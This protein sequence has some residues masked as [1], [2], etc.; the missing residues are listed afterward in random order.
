LA[1]K[2]GFQ[3]DLAE[4][5]QHLKH[6]KSVHKAVRNRLTNE[7]KKQIAEEQKK[8]LKINKTKARRYLP[9]KGF[10]PQGL[11]KGADKHALDQI[12]QAATASLDIEQ[13]EP[14]EG[15]EEDAPL[16]LDALDMHQERFDARGEPS[17]WHGLDEDV[18]VRVDRDDDEEA[19]ENH[20]AKVNT[21]ERNK[22]LLA[23]ANKADSIVPNANLRCDLCLSD[24]TQTETAKNRKY[25]LAKLNIHLGSA[26]HSRRSQI[27]RAFNLDAET[28]KASTI[29]C[30]IC[31]LG[32]TGRGSASSKFIA[33]IEEHHPEELWETDTEPDSMEVEE[34]DAEEEYVIAANE[35]EDASTG[36]GSEEQPVES[37]T[38]KGKGRAAV[39]G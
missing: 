18:V 17:A 31:G 23:W 16:N 27:L 37:Y 28:Q 32:N 15:D 33:H 3:E 24:D 35:D 7:V 6:R 21:T 19:D 11:V 14:L 1:I 10:E 13:I 26:T 30:P 8:A 4:L 29:R 20:A 2:Y 12:T 38:G 36:R 34:S 39:Q 5:D 22:F 25:S 9:G